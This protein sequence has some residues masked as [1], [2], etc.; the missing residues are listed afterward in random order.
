MEDALLLELGTVTTITL[1][2]ADKQNAMTAEM[3]RLLADAVECINASSEPRVVL[4][5]GAGRAFFG[6]W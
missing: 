3:G 5:R 1:N 6:G 2:R 4:L